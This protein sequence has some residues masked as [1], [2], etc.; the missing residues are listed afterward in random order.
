MTLTIESP[1]KL[2]REAL[3]IKGNSDP[4]AVTDYVLKNISPAEYEGYLRIFIRARV[5]NEINSSR[6]QTTQQIRTGEEFIS[7][8]SAEAPASTFVD[9]DAPPVPPK[10]NTSKRDAT[11]KMYFNQMI[12]VKDGLKRLGDLTAEDVDYVSKLRFKHAADTKSLAQSYANMA[13]EMRARKAKILEDLP[14]SVVSNA[15]KTP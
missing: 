8:G 12:T 11:I 2:I 10:L 6:N 1:S 9:I 13:A 4:D 3:K 14:Y 7:G 5:L 15:L